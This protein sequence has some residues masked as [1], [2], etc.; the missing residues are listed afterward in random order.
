M[1]SI[2]LYHVS[3]KFSSTLLLTP[4]IPDNFMTRNG[5]E[6]NIIPRICLSTSINGCLAGLSK[7]IKNKKFYVY[8]INT[9]KYIIPTVKQVPDSKITDEVWITYPINVSFLCKIKVGD[10][11]KKPL[12]YIYGNNK[13]ANIYMWNYEIIYKNNIS[14]LHKVLFV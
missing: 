1:E 6:D 12:K 10:P 13:T 4:R 8:S 9:N 2:K 7:N 14:N 11:I 3:E 5:Y